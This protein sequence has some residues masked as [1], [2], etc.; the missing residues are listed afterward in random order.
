MERTLYLELAHRLESGQP[1]AVATVVRSWGSTP[2]EVGAKMLVDAQGRIQGTIGG[3]CGEAEAWQ[4]A[5][6]VLKGAPAQVVHIDLT[7][8]I[9]SESGKVCGGRQDALVELL[10]PE[11]LM[12]R[13]L[14]RAIREGCEPGRELA[15]MVVLGPT[16]AGDRPRQGTP[17]AAPSGGP[18]AG[19]R[20]ALL[21]PEELVGTLGDGQ[22]DC[23]ALEL[24]RQCLARQRAEVVPVSIGEA[25][26]DVFIDVLVPSQDVVVAGAGHI[27]R[28]LCRMAS[29]C[30]VSRDGDR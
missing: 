16:G 14:A 25:S 22:A 17:Q 6:E 10:D 12:A 11:D 7:E 23:Q 15:L 20:L 28:P 18:A 2:R 5:R 8:D 26:F 30:G 1:V 19:T 24:A 3:G 29:L 9:D 13:A 27:A 4:V 21:G